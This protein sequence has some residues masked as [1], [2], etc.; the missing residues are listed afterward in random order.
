MRIRNDSWAKHS[1][2]FCPSLRITLVLGKDNFEILTSRVTKHQYYTCGLVADSL[3]G[4]ATHLPRLGKLEVDVSGSLL[5]QRSPKP[6][7]ERTKLM[8]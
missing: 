5:S 7:E 8:V 2:K 1:E 4:E 3:C 6:Q